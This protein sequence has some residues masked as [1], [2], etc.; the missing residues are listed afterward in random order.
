MYTYSQHQFLRPVRVAGLRLHPFTLG[1]ADVLCGLGSPVYTGK[2]PSPSELAAAFFVCSRPWKTAL[3]QISDG[4]DGKELKRTERRFWRMK[5]AR[6]D[7][8]RDL[9]S[10]YLGIFSVAPP[11]WEE[12]GGGGSVARAPWHL[13][14]F[15]ILQE[16]KLVR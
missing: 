12:A 5:P 11:R 2:A 4:S 1:H 15:C 3:E 6:L 7:A 13:A 14:V 8:M 10:E 16:N 9:F